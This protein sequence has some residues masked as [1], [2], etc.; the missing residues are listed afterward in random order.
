M[1]ANNALESY[2]YMDCPNTENYRGWKC[3]K[4]WRVC[5]EEGGLRSQPS[6]FRSQLHRPPSFLLAPNITRSTILLQS[7]DSVTINDPCIPTFPVYS[8]YIPRSIAVLPLSLSLTLLQN[9]ALVK[10]QSYTGITLHFLWTAE[11][12]WK[13]HTQTHRHANTHRAL[14]TLHWSLTPSTQHFM[15]TLPHS[16]VNSFCCPPTCYFTPSPLCSHLNIPSCL[17]LS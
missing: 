7:F 16:R 13:T 10:N 8:P 15:A 2:W 17:S 5:S 4:C 9:S 6:A 14:I 11:H 3:W 12:T 1:K